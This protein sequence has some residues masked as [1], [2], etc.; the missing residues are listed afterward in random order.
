MNLLSRVYRS[1]IG[2]KYIMAVT[3]FVLFL[4]VVGHMLGN[5]QVYLGPEPMNAYAAFLKSKPTLLWAVRAGLLLVALLHITSAVQLAAENRNARPERYAEGRPI[6]SFAS[7]TILVSGLIVFAFVI[8]HLMHFTFGVTNP[9]F[10][11]LEDSNSQHDVYRMVV[12]GFSNGWVS[13][14]YLISMGL[15]C[16]HLSHGLSSMFQSLGIRSNA[17][18]RLVTGF[19]RVSALI[20]FIGNCSI[21]IS[22]LAG[23]VN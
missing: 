12:L 1:S 8:Y 7:R 3:G 6:A 19:A 11:Q 23:V 21:P 4:F 16:L 13:S 5:L 15:L 18:L 22:I 14:F 9:E 2:K 10:M 17:N 20:I